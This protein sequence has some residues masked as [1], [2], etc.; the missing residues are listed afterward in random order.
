MAKLYSGAVG[1]VLL[2]VGIVGF[3]TP[4]LAGLMF[5][6]AHNVIHIASG[7]LGI[8]A[9]IT[10]RSKLF[11]QVFGVVYTLVAIAGFVGLHDLGSI[12]LGLDTLYNLIHVIVG[13]A[14]LFV[15]FSSAPSATKTAA[16]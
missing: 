3:L 12:Q 13:V 5:H 10:G 8:L 2:I 14:G 7:A 11:A 15:G 1:T 16:A 6:P 9:A 4:N